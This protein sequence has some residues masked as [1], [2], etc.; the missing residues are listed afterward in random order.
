M[1]PRQSA[2]SGGAEQWPPAEGSRGVSRSIEWTGLNG[3]RGVTSWGRGS[4]PGVF[5]GGC[6]HAGDHRRNG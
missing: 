4:G 5:F 6:G 1:G 3:L 2:T